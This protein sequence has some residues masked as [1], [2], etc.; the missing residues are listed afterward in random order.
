[1]AQYDLRC[2]H[3]ESYLTLTYLVITCNSHTYIITLTE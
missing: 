2:V 3:G 1:M